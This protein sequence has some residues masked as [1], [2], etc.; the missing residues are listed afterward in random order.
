MEPR[1]SR[2]IVIDW[3]GRVSIT[4][5]TIGIVSIPAMTTVFE[6]VLGSLTHAD[7]SNLAEAMEKMILSVYCRSAIKML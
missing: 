1:L 6:G 3:I 2:W 5:Q 4:D 7:V